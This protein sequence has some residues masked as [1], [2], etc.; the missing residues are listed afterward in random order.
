MKR[1]RLLAALFCC[2]AILALPMNPALPTASAETQTHGNFLYK[3]ITNRNTGYSY[4]KICGYTGNQKE[5]TLPTAIDG[6]PVESVFRLWKG[7]GECPE[8]LVIPEGVVVIGELF[9]EETQALKEAVLPST[10]KAIGQSESGMAGPFYFT[11][12]LKEL[13]IPPNVGLIC[14]NAFHKDLLLRVE[15]GS[16]AHRWAKANEHPFEV[17]AH[18]PSIGDYDADGLTTSTDARLLLQQVAGKVTFDEAQSAVADVDGDGEVTT[19]DA[20]LTLQYATGKEAVD[21]LA[22]PLTF[23]VPFLPREAANELK[24]SYIGYSEDKSLD[25]NWLAF[26]YYSV[27]V[28]LENPAKTLADINEQIG[29]TYDA[30][31]A[32]VASGYVTGTYLSTYVNGVP[33]SLNYRLSYYGLSMKL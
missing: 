14:R 29:R 7:G 28:P 9:C 22:C 5:V 19:T 23:N 17:I 20:R 30:V 1:I 24:K 2:V 31:M 16:Y 32:P 11:P 6:V 26:N 8:Q 25:V 12:S 18:V 10:L 3:V 13:T 4:V 33:F 15:A 21:T 27:S